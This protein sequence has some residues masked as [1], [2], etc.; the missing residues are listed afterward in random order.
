MH[1]LAYGLA[2]LSPLFAQ[3]AQEIQQPGGS[4]SFITGKY[5][6]SRVP[7]V[8]MANSG[9]LEMLL[10]AGRLYLSLQDAIAL[11]LENNL[12]IEL[13]R[14]GPEIADAQMLR[15]RAG[16]FAQGVSTSVTA[17]PTSAQAGGVAQ[18]GV[19][20][21]PST[22]ASAASSTAVGN[23]VI[24]Q[25]GPAIPAF[26]PALVGSATWAHQSIP[27]ST[28]FIAG[29]DELIQRQDTSAFTYQQGF[30]T[31]TSISFGLNNSTAIGNSTTA[32]FNPVT[33]SSLG[34]TVTQ[35]LLQGFSLAVNQRQIRIAKNN[36][37]LADLTF[38]L[39]VITTVA[40]V[41][42]LYWDLVTFNE[43]VRVQEQAVATSTKLYEDNKKQV[44]AGMMA[45]IEVVRAQ[46]QL[47]TDEQNLTLAET[48][49]L[50]QETILKNALS[51]TGVAS[52]SVADARIVPTDRIRVP[53]TEP[54]T[55]IQD[56]M[57]TALAARP[58]LAQNRIQVANQ[59][60]TLRGSRNGLLPTLDLVAGTTNNALAG[61]VNTLPST[62]PFSFG[63][64]SPAFIGGYG[65]VL[66]Q[67]FARNY[68]NYSAG[69]NLTI[70]LR[71]RAAQAQA[72]NDELTLRQ[73]QIGE[74]RLENQ[75][76]VDVQ[77]A[78]IGVR[79]ARAQ[80]RAAVKA[81]V[82]QAQTLDAEQKK[83]AAGASVIYN[84][85]L[86]QRDL[87]AARLSELSAEAAYA[88]SKVELERVT[89]Q[90]LQDNNISLA[91]ALRGS[92]SRPPESLPAN[93]QE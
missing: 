42:D 69:F 90:I 9:R 14:Y 18:S 8:N 75:V 73:L 20:G 60:I 56:L 4:F 16:G 44:E 31:G 25:S 1:K 87:A 74:Q 43:N 5:R 29:V 41:M 39:Q 80:Y 49:V 27:E 89:G 86:T 32:L 78:V 91:E 77:N 24:S 72:L 40:A 23:T 63:A 62:L 81:H 52:P 13:Q 12:D 57:A 88:K 38:K 82:L 83:Y 15:A 10:R 19:T 21:N 50:Q 17:G 79:N 53:D 47:A 76:R 3:Q 45:P 58:E 36:R 2:L 92:V 6:L 59:E 48:Q 66:K 64:P 28:P 35:H 37:E 30:Q 7:P 70:P 26:D 71:N 84:V 33:S 54:V 22:Q 67:L 85:I 61:Q 65:A 46:A 68:P 34:I 11:A 51:R 55:P 93:V